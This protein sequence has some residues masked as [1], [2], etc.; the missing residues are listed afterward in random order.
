LRAFGSDPQGKGALMDQLRALQYFMVAAEEGSL[1]GAARRLGVSLA[2]VAKLLTGLERELGVALFDRGSR[3]ITLTA[4]GAVYLEGCGPAVEQIVQ[5]SEL[6]RGARDR[7]RG[8]V[9]IGTPTHVARHCLLPALPHFHARYPEV[10]VDLRTVG[11]ITDPAAKGVEIYILVGWLP[12]HDLVARRL[13]TGSS[14]LCAAPAYWQA[15]G[16]PERPGDLHAHNC[17]AYRNPDGVL[18]DHWRFRRGDELESV[19]VRGWVTSG[20]REAL[21]DLVLAGKGVM[22]LSN[23][24]VLDHI[25]SARLMPALRDWELLDTPPV[26]LLYRPNHRR[27]PRLRAFAD[28]AIELFA[29]LEAD[30]QG[31]LESVTRAEAPRWHNRSA[32]R[33]SAI[34]KSA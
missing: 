30:L 11:R 3:G 5:T 9:V 31:G 8:T 15:H 34:F 19:S 29:S 25:R 14:S 10:D 24:S 18:L 6:L 28:F 27:I 23:V 13:A 4:D 12:P 20:D 1:S 17:F 2:A 7:P 33:A 32:L 21:L 16:L 26:S 22:R